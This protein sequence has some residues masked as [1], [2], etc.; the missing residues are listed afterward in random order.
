LKTENIYGI[1]YYGVI[2][3][4]LIADVDDNGIINML[5]L[6]I[7]AVKFGTTCLNT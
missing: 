7:C 2:M 5:D 3:A 4:V 6:Y 1:N